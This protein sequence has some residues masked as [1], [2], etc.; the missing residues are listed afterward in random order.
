MKVKPAKDL[1]EFLKPYAMKAGVTVEEIEVKNSAITIFIEK[2]GGVDLDTCALFHRLILEPIDDFDPSFG[3]AYTLNVSSL[4]ADRPFKTEQ[5][6]LSHVGKRVEVRLKESIRGKKFYEG[7]LVSYSE[8]AVTLKVDEKNTF[9][10]DLKN[11]VK[12]NE[13]IDFE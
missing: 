1:I 2:D 9:T 7:T 12:M 8:K 5:D 6:F 3:E 4:G 13:Y 10:I 11:L